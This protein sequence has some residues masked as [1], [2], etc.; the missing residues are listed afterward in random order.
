MVTQSPPGLP[1]AF[2]KFKDRIMCKKMLI[3]CSQCYCFKT[4]FSICLQVLENYDLHTSHYLL[5]ICLRHVL[6]FPSNFLQSVT[7]SKF[8]CGL[9]IDIKEVRN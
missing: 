9:D 2:L 5:L 3:R 1:G 4:L 6:S 8:I 7:M